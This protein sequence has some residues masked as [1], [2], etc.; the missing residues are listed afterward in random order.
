MKG[1]NDTHKRPTANSVSASCHSWLNATSSNTPD[2]LDGI[3]ALTMGRRL[4]HVLHA[5]LPCLDDTRAPLPHWQPPP[6]ITVPQ[7]QKFNSQ[8]STARNMDV[9]RGFGAS[10][11]RQASPWCLRCAGLGP[12]D[13]RVHRLLRFTKWYK[14]LF[15]RV[16]R[17]PLATWS[18]NIGWMCGFS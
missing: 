11:N 7:L 13:M 4:Q 1:R 15:C 3:H 16:P 5:V 17:C 8:V 12:G 2:I 10:H 18:T 14:V 9:V 6:G